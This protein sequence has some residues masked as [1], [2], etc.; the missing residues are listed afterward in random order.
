[1]ES[2]HYLAEAVDIDLGAILAPKGLRGPHLGR[3]EAG[4]ARQGLRARDVG[5]QKRRHT[6][7]AD[8][9]DGVALAATRLWCGE[10]QLDTDLKRILG[11]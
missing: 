9:E 2:G 8:L 10:I 1:M 11:R 4:G 5:G 7:I 6:K 3:R